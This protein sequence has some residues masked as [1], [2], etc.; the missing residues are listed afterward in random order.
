MSRTVTRRRLYG[1]SQTRLEELFELRE[2][3]KEIQ[4]QLRVLEALRDDH[5]TNIV[6]LLEHGATVEPGAIIPNTRVERRRAPKWK[7]EYIKELGFEKANE[8]IEHTV[9]HERTV[10]D[11][12]K[13]HN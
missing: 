12:V 10:L 6:E 13:T 9:P 8:V 4:A 5:E 1:L 11:L 3:I 7:E 2:Q